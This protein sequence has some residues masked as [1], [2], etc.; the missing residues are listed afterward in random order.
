M[1]KDNELALWRRKKW[2]CGGTLF[3]PSL[4]VSIS[5]DITIGW[6]RLTG[7]SVWDK[8]VSMGIPSNGCPWA[9]IRHIEAP[10]TF[11]ANRL[12]PGLFL[13]SSTQVHCDRVGFHSWNL[14]QSPEDH[15]CVYQFSWA[16]VWSLS[17]AKDV[18]LPLPASEST[19]LRT[20]G[21]WLCKV[22]GSW[23][24]L[25]RQLLAD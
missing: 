15:Q 21:M 25:L 22:S 14:H 9:N 2:V 17:R 24:M 3:H 11:S 4:W 10:Q 23:N 7:L 1:E 6:L 8:W 12:S 19:R 16:R 13:C 18:T 5:Y 20:E